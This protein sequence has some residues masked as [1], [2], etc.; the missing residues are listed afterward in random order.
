MIPASKRDI[1]SEENL[2]GTVESSLD[3]GRVI[4]FSDAIVSARCCGIQIRG[5]PSEERV[6]KG[7]HGAREALKSAGA[8]SLSP[9]V[10]GDI[11]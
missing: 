10:F 9:D 3:A 8:G 6:L 2:G 4:E 7:L 1:R 11:S 5:I